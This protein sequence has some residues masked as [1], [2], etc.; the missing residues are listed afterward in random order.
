[1]YTVMRRYDGVP[2]L[3]EALERRQD[4]VKREMSAS[5][6]FVAYYAIRDGKAMTTVTVAQTRA[7]AEESTRR[8]AQWL[9][10]QLPDIKVR[11][12]DVSG[13]EVFIHTP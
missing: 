8:V 3:I 4:E 2:A 7:D 12:P 11:P 6:G 9:K 13:G 10:E 1:M 5:P